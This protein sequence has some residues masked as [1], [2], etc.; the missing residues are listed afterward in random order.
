[1]SDD[2]FYT[3]FGSQNRTPLSYFMLLSVLRSRVE[4]GDEAAPGDEDVNIYLAR[5]LGAA[6]DPAYLDWSRRFIFP[7]S[8]D[9]YQSL[10]E[11]ADIRRKYTTYKI[12]A[13]HLLLEIGIFDREREG[14]PR[15][16]SYYAF[17]NAYSQQLARRRT[18]MADVLDKM[19]LNFDRYAALLGI[20]RREY[21]NLVETLS[22]RAMATI[23]DDIQHRRF[24]AIV[25][26]LLDA[27]SQ[28]L[29]TSRPA[30]IAEMRALVA[31]ARKIEPEF[32]FQIPEGMA[33]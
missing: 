18:G 5:T 13:D 22:Q 17:A 15:G 11:S 20:V 23:H 32:A 33:S 8:L 9:V 28:W 27:Y 21:F 19:A 14:A 1:M 6:A 24:V 31:E 7:Y 2:L 16:R 3:E 25:D 26:A 4:S 30:L 29:Q 12:N 10:Q